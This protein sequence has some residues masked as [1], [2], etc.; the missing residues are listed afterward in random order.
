M[1]AE[2]N[3]L[4][5]SEVNLIVGSCGVLEEALMRKDSNREEEAWGGLCLKAAIHC[6]AIRAWSS[7]SFFIP[8]LKMSVAFHK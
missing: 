4:L 5:G 3:Y 1:P 7:V 2:F 6:V 8:A